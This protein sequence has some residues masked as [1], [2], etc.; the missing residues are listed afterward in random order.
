MCADV[1]V[2]MA[3]PEDDLTNRNLTSSTSNPL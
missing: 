1:L 3:S 2:L